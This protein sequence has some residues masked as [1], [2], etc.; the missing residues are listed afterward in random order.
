MTLLECDLSANDE[1]FLTIKTLLK[2]YTGKQY[3]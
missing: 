3:F 2:L 1:F